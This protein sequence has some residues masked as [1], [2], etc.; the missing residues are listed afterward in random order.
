MGVYKRGKIYWI[1]Y[2]VSGKALYESSKSEKK[3]DAN[4]L[5]IKRKFEAQQGRVI[6]KA[7]PMI[8]DD[9]QNNHIVYHNQHGE[10]VQQTL[11]PI[12]FLRWYGMPCIY[13]LM[14]NQECVYVGKTLNLP[15][16][17]QQHMGDFNK[18]F[19]RAFYFELPEHLL[20]VIEKNIIATLQPIYNRRILKMVTNGYNSHLSDNKKGSSE[21]DQSLDSIGCPRGDSNTRHRD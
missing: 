5:L 15:Y 4:K 3:A 2:Y 8:Y 14:Q 21:D 13:L 19:S 18:K 11:E 9:W 12:P 1:K 10:K 17:L 7:S 6:S 20:D 16:R